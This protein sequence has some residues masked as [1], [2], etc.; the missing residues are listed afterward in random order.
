MGCNEKRVI[1]P[2]HAYRRDLEHC[3]KYAAN[4]ETVSRRIFQMEMHLGYERSLHFIDLM[5][6]RGYIE[7][8]AA[9]EE[10]RVNY[11]PAELDQILIENDFEVCK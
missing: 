2:A 9:D 7:P 8:G 11:G 3:L 5:A 10:R 1:K 4:Q 6:N